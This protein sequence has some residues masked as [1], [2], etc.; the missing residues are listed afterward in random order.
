MLNATERDYDVATGE[1]VIQLKPESAFVGTVTKDGVPQ[2]N[3]R[4]SVAGKV[5]GDFHKM[6]ESVLTDEQGKYK[7]GCL[8]PGTYHVRAANFTRLAT[9]GE[10]ET[11]TLD[12]GNNLGPI[13]IHAR[14]SPVSL[15][16]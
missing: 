16:P 4:V 14:R 11:A 1:L 15:S 10:G 6:Y 9:V 7:Y 2:V 13:R 8:T 3:V 5:S 12:L